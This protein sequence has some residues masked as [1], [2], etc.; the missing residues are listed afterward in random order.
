MIFI[1]RKPVMVLFSRFQSLLRINLR[2]IS[3]VYSKYL[4]F[5]FMTVS[6]P[7]IV[8]K[9]WQKFIRFTV[10][11]F[12]FFLTY[13]IFFISIFKK[14]VV[15]AIPSVK[16]VYVDYTIRFLCSPHDN[17]II[18]WKCISPR[19]NEKQAFK[20]IGLK[21]MFRCAGY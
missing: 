9:L 18:E 10:D 21:A 12:V 7:I 13:S 16:N 1:M 19:F 4:P 17:E 6:S 5:E 8:S 2:W 14:N 3:L 20:I 15:I 11:Q